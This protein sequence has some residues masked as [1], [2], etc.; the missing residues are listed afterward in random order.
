[1]DNYIHCKEI[2]S[3]F[4]SGYRKVKTKFILAIITVVKSDDY[5]LMQT[6]NSLGHI[7]DEV[8][9]IIQAHCSTY[10][11]PKITGNIYELRS[12]DTGI[13]N[14]MNRALEFVDADWVLF[15]NAGDCLEISL[16]KLVSMLN[17]IK[18]RSKRTLVFNWLVNNKLRTP[19]IY[20]M[21]LGSA[22]SHQAAII[23]CDQFKNRRYNEKFKLAADYLF[24]L[25]SHVTGV[26]LHYRSNILSQVLPGGVSDVKRRQVYHEFLK[27]QNTV[28]YDTRVSYFIF[29]L[30][31]LLNEFKSLI[32][33]FLRK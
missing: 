11:Q 22:F 33:W 12:S 8:Q 3:N 14:A 18:I 7:P 27:A 5:A 6:R 30:S 21:R 19:K 24:F 26:K 2:R 9:W 15:M 10:H 1:M 17:S 13:Y 20:K 28:G 23:S 31:Y 29:L 4:L 32:K 16:D 25:E